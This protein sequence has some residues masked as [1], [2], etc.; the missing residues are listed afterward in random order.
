MEVV[1]YRSLY[2]N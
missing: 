1:K 2:I